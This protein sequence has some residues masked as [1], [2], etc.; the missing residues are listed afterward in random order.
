MP[1]KVLDVSL[2][3]N[4]VNVEVRRSQYGPQSHPK[5]EKHFR[6]ARVADVA[7]VNNV[8]GLPAEPFA[9]PVG[10]FPLGRCVVATDEQVV[11]AWHTR[12]INHDVAVYGVEGLHH[13]HVGKFALDLFSERIG[14]GQQGRH[15]LGGVQRIANL[16][17]NLGAQVGRT[18]QAKGCERVRPVGAVEDDFAEFRCVSERADLRFAANAAKPLLTCVAL[19]FARAHHD[20]M[21]DRHEF[22]ADSVADHTGAENRDFHNF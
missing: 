6:A 18:S 2:S 1:L 21:A 20:L 4:D 17:E 22:G 13:A 12:R 11:I 15:S 5:R 10:D 14:V 7:E 8:A 3:A 9:K 19:G 16:D